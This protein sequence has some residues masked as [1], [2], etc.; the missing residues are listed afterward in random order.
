MPRGLF[1]LFPVFDVFGPG[2]QKT[3]AAAFTPLSL[4]GLLDWWDAND[5]TK[6]FTTVGGGT[7][8]AAN[9]DAVKQGNSKGPG[10]HNLVATANTKGGVLATGV[11]GINGLPT[12]NFAGGAGQTGLRVTYTQAQP[13]YVFIVANVIGAVD[14]YGLFDG[15]TSDSMEMRIHAGD[16]TKFDIYAGAFLSQLMPTNMGV[17]HQI[18]VY[19]NGASSQCWQDSASFATGN[20]GAT[21]TAGFTLANYGDDSGT[22]ALNCL[23]GEVVTATSMSAGDLT[24]LFAYFRS[25]WGVS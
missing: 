16:H 24:N 2:S 7:N 15:G 14:N 17:A 3:L 10:G 1:D 11:N 9:G 6:A 13:V 22:R 21:T 18:G 5:L 25:K 8:P 4:S 19:F 12:W 20:V 23:V